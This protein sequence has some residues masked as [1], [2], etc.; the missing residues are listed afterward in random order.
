MTVEKAMEQ[1]QESTDHLLNLP[2]G[3]L[4]LGSIDVEDVIFILKVHSKSGFAL[5]FGDKVKAPLDEAP[6]SQIDPQRNMPYSYRKLSSSSTLP[7]DTSWK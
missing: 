4:K 5:R 1:N 2:V 6:E 3:C 7:S